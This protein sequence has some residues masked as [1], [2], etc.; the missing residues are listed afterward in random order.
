[1][2]NQGS[3]FPSDSHRRLNV[4]FIVAFVIS[5]IVL[6]AV[7]AKSSFACP[8]VPPVQHSLKADPRY[9]QDLRPLQVVDKEAVKRNA[10]A[11]KNLRKFSSLVA[12]LSDEAIDGNAISASCL[13]HF[14]D[15]WASQDALLGVARSPQARYERLW[16]LAGISLSAYKLKRSGY[17]LSER[18]RV[19]LRELAG[20]VRDEQKRRNVPNNLTVWAALGT[21]TTAVLTDDEE[22]WNWSLERVHR[23]LAQIEADGT[24]PTELSRR[25]RATGYHFYAGQPLI[26]FKLIATCER[27]E[28]PAI[29][30]AAYERFVTLLHKLESGEVLLDEKAGSSQLPL[31]EQVWLSVLTSDAPYLAEG[32]DKKM[33]QLGGSVRRLRKVTDCTH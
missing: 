8:V 5:S 19:W 7:P 20:V 3:F 4:G 30:Q 10:I 23:F 15:D 13:N 1:M 26:A 11:Q 27:R 24:A 9:R 12:R 17:E 33:T 21:A 28:I 22:L 16:A 6:L 29:D 14:F 18:T 25:E 2:R 32:R 31:G